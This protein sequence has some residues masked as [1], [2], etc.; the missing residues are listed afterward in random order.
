MDD[1]KG[2]LS[3]HHQGSQIIPRMTV[4][5]CVP[6]ATF[7]GT[8]RWAAPPPPAP[9]DTTGVSSHIPVEIPQTCLEINGAPSTGELQAM[10][11]KQRARAN[12]RK[13]LLGFHAVLLEGS[14][15]TKEARKRA[16]DHISLHHSSF[17]FL[18]AC[19]SVYALFISFC[20]DKRTQGEMPP[21]RTKHFGRSSVSRLHFRLSHHVIRT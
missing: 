5:G 15:A 20:F 6:R 7:V 3:N 19:S 10:S 1:M 21:S 11:K 14:T 2:F 8:K 12:I 16:P 18:V 17:L 9:L 13:H 4:D